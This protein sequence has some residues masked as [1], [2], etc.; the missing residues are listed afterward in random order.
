MQ[1][2]HIKRQDIKPFEKNPR[3]HS[4][5]Q[6]A[7]IRDSIMEFGFNNPVLIDENNIIIAGHGRVLALDDFHK[8]NDFSV[9]C[10]RLEHL[11][12][13]QK[14]AYIV[15]DNKSYEMGSWDTELLNKLEEESDL[16]MSMLDD[17]DTIFINNP[18]NP[19]DGLIDKKDNKKNK[20]CPHCGGVL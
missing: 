15:I 20:L 6:V 1:I 18:F 3:L 17:V 10:I 11:T 19:E 8:E 4:S 7:F 2:E 5:E 13:E 16:L 9:P 14:K 12:E